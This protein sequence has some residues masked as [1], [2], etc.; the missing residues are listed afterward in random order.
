MIC[1]LN[2]YIFCYYQKVYSIKIRIKTVLE[3]APVS[4]LELDQKVYS[5]KTRIRMRY[6]L[7]IWRRYAKNWKERL[8]GIKKLINFAYM[9]T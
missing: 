6:I 3:L 5:I 2:I 8:F 1:K 7:F 9:D 4:G